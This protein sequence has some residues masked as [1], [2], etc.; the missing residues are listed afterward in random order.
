MYEMQLEQAQR[1]IT[2]GQ[3]VVNQLEQARKDAE[4]DAA[5]AR[6]VARK[7]REQYMFSK[8][9]EEGRKE[10]YDEGFARGREMALAEL[11]KTNSATRQRGVN[12]R[13]SPR[14][15]P[16][17]DEHMDGPED[18]SEEGSPTPMPIPNRSPPAEPPRSPSVHSVPSVR[19]SNRPTAVVRTYPPRSVYF[20]AD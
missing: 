6:S 17:E 10:G 11:R 8:A 13:P 14:R 2:R 3:E 12:A 4:E 5:R 1:E 19:R 16:L 9:R 18:E 15:T 20:L 7:L